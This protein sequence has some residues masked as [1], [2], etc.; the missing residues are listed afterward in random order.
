MINLYIFL[1]YNNSQYHAYYC[2]EKENVL[3]SFVFAS[4]FIRGR[5]CKNYFPLMEINI[6]VCMVVKGMVMISRNVSQS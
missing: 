4:L 1:G 2:D 3:G 5:Y 6:S